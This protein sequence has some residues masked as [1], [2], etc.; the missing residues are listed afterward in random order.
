MSVIKEIQDGLKAFGELAV[1]PLLAVAL[2]SGFFLFSPSSLLDSAGMTDLVRDYR[3]WLGMAFVLS[4]AYLVAHA[5]K[6]FAD[7]LKSWNKARLL[8]KQRLKW[9]RSLTPDEKARL[10]PYIRD[11]RASVT[12]P[13]EDGVI[14]SLQ[15]KGILSRAT[16]IGH[17]T[18]GFPYNL[19]S[20]AREVLTESPEYLDGAEE[21]QRTPQDWMGL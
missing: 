12:Y 5:V 14:G 13:V 9:L 11:E 18:R 16:S 3:S 10:I 15:R 8:N 4:C 7:G 21:I 2:S 6:Y 1:K 20:W 17:A 19:Q